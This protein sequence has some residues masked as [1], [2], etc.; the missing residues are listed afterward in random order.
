MRDIIFINSHPIQYFSPLYAYLNTQGMNVSC[1]YCSDENVKGHVDRQFGQQVA[2][3][4]PLL[5]GYSYRFFQN[6]SWKPS[7]YNGFFGLI[8]LGMIRALFSI[9]KSTI[10]VHGWAYLSHVLVIWVARLSGHTVCLR[11]ESPLNQEMLKSRLNRLV[12][13]VVFRNFLFPFVHKFLFIGSQN[14]GFYEHFGVKESKMVFV[15]YAVD[16][17]RFQKAAT[18]LVPDKKQLRIQLGFPVEAKIILFA[19]KFIDKKRPMDLIRAYE[20]LFADNKCLV[21]VGEGELRKPMEAYIEEKNL[22]CVY[23]PGFINQSEIVKYYAIADV[24]VLC[25]ADGETWGLSVNEALNFNLK[26]IVSDLAGCAS[27]LIKSEQN[28]FIIRV[29]DVED[30]KRMLQKALSLSDGER[31]TKTILDRF[32]FGTIATSLRSLERSIVRVA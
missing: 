30:L 18:R 16:N 14:R 31:E 32:S 6:Y 29:G 17:D 26:V 1:W 28:G 23:L 20:S 11:G 4:I 3:D 22:S 15:P 13:Q 12:K 24:F 25:S 27:D 21:M 5:E 7:L 19:A 2:W 10:I 8:N 9:K